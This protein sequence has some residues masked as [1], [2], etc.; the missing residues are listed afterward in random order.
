MELKFCGL[1]QS[2]KL[3]CQ[4]LETET[5]IPALR[6]ELS[7]YT[8]GLEALVMGCCWGD[9]ISFLLQPEELVTVLHFT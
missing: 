5:K 9:C 8:S 7:D 2:G 3:V 1:V 4:L 6:I